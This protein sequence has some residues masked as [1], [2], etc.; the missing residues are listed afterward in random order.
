MTGMLAGPDCAAA[1]LFAAFA[2]LR[3]RA[4]G[5]AAV[6][7][8]ADAPGTGAAAWLLLALLCVGVNVAALGAEALWQRTVERAWNA[9][10]ARRQF[11]RVAAGAACTE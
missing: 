1:V 10:C 2:V 7:S 8:S 9:A 11:E 3:A 5:T 6:H 4:A